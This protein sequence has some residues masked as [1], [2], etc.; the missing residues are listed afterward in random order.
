[1]L[2]VALAAAALLIHAAGAFAQ[3]RVSGV[4]NDETGKPIKAAT[5]TAE[6]EN[7]N[8]QYTA[9][10]DDKGRFSLIGL[11][12]GR[13]RFV[14]S[15][16]G[17]FGD[18]GTAAIRS[19]GTNPPIAFSL[20]KTSQLAGALGGVTAKDLQEDLAAADSLFNQQKWDES[21]AAYKAIIQKTPTLS[22]INLQI[23]AAQSNKKD[24]D[25]AL[26]T[27]DELLKADPA[28]EKATVGAART[29]LAKGDAAAAEDALTKAA[30]TPEA[31][32]ETFDALGD[33]KFEKGQIDEAQSW[34]QKAADSDPSW[35]KAWYKLGLCAQKKGDNAGVNNFMNKVLAVDPVSP[36]A[37]MAKATLDQLSR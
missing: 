13:W 32:R 2:S 4:V 16:P 30:A 17:Y 25:A 7:A 23:A 31:G 9:T 3:G 36:E 18:E 11:R 8:L 27:Y 15:A 26:A 20:K 10:T 35:G 19:G 22:V 34:Y 37:A 24:Y 28:N 1:M 14:A 33:L 29:L 12:G 5:V 6:F 21:I